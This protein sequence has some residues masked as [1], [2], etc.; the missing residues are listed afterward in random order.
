MSR[1][2]C[3]VCTLNLFHGPHVRGPGGPA[4]AILPHHFVHRHLLL[5]ED[6]RGPPI[7][8]QLSL[9]IQCHLV[10]DWL[11]ATCA[12]VVRELTP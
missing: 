5:E 12:L 1:A 10:L 2:E 11:I 3:Y 6:G 9:A 4:F 7:D 8:S